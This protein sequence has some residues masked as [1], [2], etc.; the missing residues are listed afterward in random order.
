M[1]I[2]EHGARTPADSRAAVNRGLT[3]RQRAGNDGATNGRHR[4]ARTNA[5][6]KRSEI[7]KSTHWQREFEWIRTH[8]DEMRR[9][10]GQWV[11]LEGEQ[12]VAHGKS[13]VRVV[14]GARRKGVAVP[15]VFYVEPPDVAPTSHFGL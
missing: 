5:A 6:R 8:A 11:V 4:I 13:A 10:A 12:V 9:L 15:F 1:P 14:A 2:R 7:I 3:E